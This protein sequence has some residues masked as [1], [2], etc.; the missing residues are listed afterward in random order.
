MT[1][2]G[3]T[4]PVNVS[5]MGFLV[6]TKGTSPGFDVR[7]LEQEIIRG[8][9]STKAKT[10]LAD[11]FARD[12]GSISA[13]LPDRP[14]P[15]D[16]PAQKSADPFGLLEL[17]TPGMPGDDIDSLLKMIDVPGSSMPVVPPRSSL[18]HITH[19]ERRQQIINNAYGTT[20]GTSS[21]MYSIEKEREDDEKAR[22]LEQIGSLL[23]ILSDE[24]EENIK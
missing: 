6:D 13:P 15:F 5:G 23:E 22:D 9:S 18:S 24:G 4:D 19:E 8:I 7:A 16:P 11:E 14:I 2:L 17:D 12:V 3:I 20:G 10:S 21:T 1:D